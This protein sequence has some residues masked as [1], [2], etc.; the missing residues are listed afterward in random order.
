MQGPRH[1]VHLQ[2][3]RPHLGDQTLGFLAAPDAVEPRHVGLQPAAG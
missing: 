1:P 2:A 3:T